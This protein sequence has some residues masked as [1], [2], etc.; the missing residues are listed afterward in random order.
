MGFIS[1]GYR[2]PQYVD[3]EHFR[4]SASNLSYNEKE[5]ESLRSGRSSASAGVPDA[6]TFDK[7]ISGGTCPV[8]ISE[9]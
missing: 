2:R 9:F 1:L 4:Q 5:D 8:S 7:I 6:L 3:R